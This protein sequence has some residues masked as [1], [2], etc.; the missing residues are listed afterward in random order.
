MNAAH[1]TGFGLNAVV[2]PMSSFLADNASCLLWQ[3]P[4]M[5]EYAIEL[6][7]VDRQ[8][9][10]APGAHTL[11]Q[12]PPI[13]VLR[14]FIER[15]VERHPSTLGQLGLKA[16]EALSWDFSFK[17]GP[18]RVVDVTADVTVVFTDLEGFTEYT[19]NNGDEAALALLDK[20][21]KTIM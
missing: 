1:L 9:L 2:A 3:R 19:A 18:S 14:R 17:R 16:I 21:N 10:E 12:T 4:E 6:G 11:S 8:W 7:L 5:R 20:Y 15:A 13:D